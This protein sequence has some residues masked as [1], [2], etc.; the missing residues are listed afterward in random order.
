MYTILGAR[1]ICVKNSKN[2][3]ETVVG[4]TLQGDLARSGR[5]SLARGEWLERAYP[6]RGQ[7]TQEGVAFQVLLRYGPEEPRVVRVALLSPMTKTCPRVTFTGPKAQVLGI[8]LTQGLAWRYGSS[9][10]SPLT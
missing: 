4:M 8:Y 9:C 5:A 3:A 10:G 7:V 6:V 2:L 1:E